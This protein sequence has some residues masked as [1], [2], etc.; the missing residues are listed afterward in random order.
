MI[1]EMRTTLV[2]PFA[3]KKF[4]ER[5]AQ[6]LPERQKLS[7]L[8]GFFHT[9]VGT[10]NQI[11]E[12]WPYENMA[13]REDAQARAAKIG[14][15]PDSREFVIEQDAKILKRAPF[16][17][18][19]KAGKFGNVYE[20]RQYIYQA[21]TIPRVIDAWIPLIEARMKL[22]PMTGAWYTDIGPQHQ[23]V[24][25]W[26]FQDAAERQ[27]IRAEAVERKMWPPVTAEWLL[28]M[29]NCLALPAPFSPL[30]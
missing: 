9:D 6:A 22:S 16:S 20:I 17:P 24:H 14:W 11:I 28:R 18:P 10:L 13:Q 25:I 30:R 19:F 1:V 12:L 26:P 23:W 3:A 5:F 2:K 15:P 8:G 21:G 7:P 27:R 4:E 29:E